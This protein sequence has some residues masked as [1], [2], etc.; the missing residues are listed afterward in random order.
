MQL[1]NRTRFYKKSRDQVD[2]LIDEQFLS[3][4]IPNVSSNFRASQKS[5]K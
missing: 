5:C 1:Q 3:K 4:N 2:D